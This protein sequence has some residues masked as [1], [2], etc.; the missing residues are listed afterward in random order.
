M[1]NLLKSELKVLGKIVD[2]YEAKPKTKQY[3]DLCGH[4]DNKYIYILRFLQKRRTDRHF[5][6][7]HK[8][9]GISNNTNVDIPDLQ[10]DNVIDI[11]TPLNIH[12]RTLDTTS[13][14]SNNEAN[15]I[16]NKDKAIIIETLSNLQDI[17]DNDKHLKIES[18]FHL[19]AI[20]INDKTSN[21]EIGTTS[22]LHEATTKT[23]SN[24]RKHK[25]KK[26]YIDIF[27]NESLIN[28]LNKAVRK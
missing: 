12:D 9:Y 17:N 26:T 2:T 10:P 23:A 25:K 18:T 16:N 24:K 4:I 6:N 20:N 21:K 3:M 28:E 5:R 1:L 22:Q 13:T 11:E 15:D 14:I 27:D 19:H 7:T 8:K